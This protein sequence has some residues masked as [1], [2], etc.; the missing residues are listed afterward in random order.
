MS[1]ENYNQLRLAIQKRIGYQVENLSEIKMLQEAIE[2]N[3]KK[4]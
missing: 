2:W 4:K 3:T 1:S